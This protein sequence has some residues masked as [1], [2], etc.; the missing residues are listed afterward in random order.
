MVHDACIV[1]GK[2]EGHGRVHGSLLHDA[3]E[4]LGRPQSPHSRSAHR[5]RQRP[6]LAAKYGAGNGNALRWPSGHLVRP[7][8]LPALRDLPRP[9]AGSPARGAQPLRLL[10]GQDGFGILIRGQDGQEVIGLEDKANPSRRSRLSARRLSVLRSCL[11]ASGC[12]R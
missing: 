1:G 12:P 2:N 8:S 4:L 3:E 10:A 11:R 7:S 5:P 9:G 6:G